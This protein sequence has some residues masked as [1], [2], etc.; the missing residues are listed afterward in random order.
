MRYYEQYAAGESV[1][2]PK[3]YPL[4]W[5]DVQLLYA[6]KLA[7]ITDTS[8]EESRRKMPISQILPAEV[9]TAEASTQELYG[10]FA[11]QEDSDYAPS[12]RFGAFDY[13]Y[14]PDSNLIKVHFE[15][16][17]RGISP[18]AAD[19]LPGRRA[20]FRDM[21]Q[22]ARSEYPEAEFCMSATWLRAT[23]GYRELFPPTIAED[24]DLMHPDMSFG[25]NYVWGQFIDRNGNTNE[26]AASQF[27][28]G[29]LAAETPADMIDA[30]PLRAK[31]V[32][33]PIQL[34]YDYYDV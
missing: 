30:F 21:L 29:V 26:R 31:M 25:L 7:A 23:E 4:G 8:A 11:D 22:A 28:E 20:E 14:N 18:L 33:D 12:H 15:N 32:H 24:T 27:L 2:N 1:L 16:P 3:K 5:F 17:Q 10:H 34:Y 9:I 13:G 19:K 6:D